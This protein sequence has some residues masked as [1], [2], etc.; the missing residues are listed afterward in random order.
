MKKDFNSF[1]IYDLYQAY[2]DCRKNKRNTINAIE[3]EQDLETNIINLYNDLLL[4]E[5]KI[6]TSICFISRYPKPRE[7]FAANFRD[8]VVHHLVYNKLESIF[9]KTFVYDSAASQIWKWVLFAQNRLYWHMQSVTNNFSNKAYYLQM[10]MKNFFPSISK[11]ILEKLLSSNIPDW[12]YKNLTLQILWHNPTLDFIFRWDKNL[13][14]KIPKSKS[15]FFTDKNRWLPIGNL[16]SQFFANIYL[17]LLDNYIKRELKCKYYTRYVDDFIILSTD[18][19]QL[20]ILR[21]KIK[22]FTMQNLDI[23]VHPNKIIMQSIDQGIN[24]VGAILKPYLRYTRNRTYWNFQRVLYKLESKIK[25]EKVVDRV[26]IISQLNSYMWFIK[27]S[28]YKKRFVDIYNK[29]HR[30]LN[31][32]FY[33][34][35][36]R[37]CFVLRE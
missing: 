8:R 3:F 21:E 14:T 17:N 10:D 29:Y 33:L 9:A 27:Q 2:Y 15:L 23:Q 35:L 26:K 24:Y 4:W 7:I 11:D 16:T 31:I 12:F 6:G 19:D 5:Y 13:Y 25:Y 1:Q 36:D 28:N 30:E 34:D 20:K 32:Y 37:M 18:K 22:I